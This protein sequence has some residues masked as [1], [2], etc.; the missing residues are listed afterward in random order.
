MDKAQQV[1]LVT[2]NFTYHP[3]KPGQQDRYQDLRAN[4]LALALLIIETTPYSREQSLA[5][6]KLEEAI[7]WAN[8]SI[9]RNE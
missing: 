3:P 4:A 9:A 7:M 6:T 5:L 1:A 8:A 2:R